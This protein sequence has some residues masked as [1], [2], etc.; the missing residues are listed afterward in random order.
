MKKNK[1][2]GHPRMQRSSTAAKPH[3][4]LRSRSMRGALRCALYARALFGMSFV[5]HLRKCSG[6]NLR[7]LSEN[8]S[9]IQMLDSRLKRAGM[10]FFL[11]LLIFSQTIF[12][13]T[14]TGKANFSGTAPQMEK[15]SMAADPVCSSLHPEPVSEETVLVN[16]NGT[17]KNVF[18]YVKEGLEGKT[19]P[20]PTTLVTI[21]QS[22]CQ[23]HPHVFGIQVG[24]PLELINRGSRLDNVH[25][26]A[27]QS[28]SFNLGMPLQG[29]KLTKKFENPEIMVKFK[30]D[31]HPWMNAYIGVLTHPYY[32]VS[33]DEGTFEI[34][35]LPA[36][37]YVIEAWHEKYGTQTQN[38]TVTEDTPAQIEFTFAG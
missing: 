9:G 23:Y 25:S 29:M 4:F 6:R 11:S 12:A 37:D 35:D 22:G 20:A 33:G 16:N 30:C 5:A 1:I 27:E 17:L 18:V 8:V 31:V 14:V 2:L 26:L 10:T 13:G 38:I 15:I 32:N 36:G 21:N 34:K 24:Q 3:V 7:F 28:K 19:F